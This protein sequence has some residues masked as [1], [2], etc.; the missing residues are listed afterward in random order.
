MSFVWRPI[1]LRNSLLALTATTVPR[2]ASAVLFALVSRRLGDQVAGAY[3]LA[4]QYLSFFL[5]LSFLG[6]DEF[7]VRDVARNRSRVTRY[8]TNFGLLQ[9]VSSL[10]FYSLLVIGAT[11][12]FSY[13]RDTTWIIIVVGL[14]IITEGMTR[15]CQLLFTAYEEQ[16]PRARLALVHM[17]SAVFF[18]WLALR[19]T[20]SIRVFL[21]VRLLISALTSLYAVLLMWRHVLPCASLSS[22]ASEVSVRW[23]LRQV[24]ESHPFF[25]MMLL[26]IID[27]QADAFI[28]SARRPQ[29]EIAWYHAVQIVF[30]SY[31]IALLVYRQVVFPRMS[32]L[33][34]NAQSSFAVIH[35]LSFYLLST[36]ALP[37]V[38]E[39]SIFAPRLIAIFDPGFPLVAARTL[40]I[41]ML[42]LFI[43][44]ATEPNCRALIISNRQR[45]VVVFMALSACVNIALNI[46]LVPRY[47]VL[48][49]AVARVT[50]VAVFGVLVSRHVFRYVRRYNPWS[51]LGRLTIF[52]IIMLGT[53]LLLVRWLAWWMAGGIGGLVFVALYVRFNG[54][55]QPAELSDLVFAPHSASDGETA[56]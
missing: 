42:A 2:I 5:P 54:I 53:S 22:V 41:L 47:G 23:T 16:G 7:I 51:G 36:L 9:C 19:A 48:S 44:F 29:E 13:S 21:L 56:Q 6:L 10:L 52:G 31:M 50:S 4:L 17:L 8:A 27:W 46:V 25:L 49:C 39:T 38:I 28:L 20:G 15:F 34:H 35:D 30:S 1:I 40:R 12:G 24:L 3:A 26:Y 37:L 43:A 55:L 33:Y 32:I 11:Q 14:L 45:E 18:C